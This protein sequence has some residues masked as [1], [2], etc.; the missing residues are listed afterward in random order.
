MRQL[1]EFIL[2]LR[3]IQERFH[4]QCENELKRRKDLENY[5][6]I[7]GTCNEVEDNDID[8]KESFTL[9]VGTYENII[10]EISNSYKVSNIK[11]ILFLR[12]NYLFILFI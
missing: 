5:I 12:C 6:E 7:H 3:G 1:F 4:S 10:K 11:V 9:E 8:I 2:E